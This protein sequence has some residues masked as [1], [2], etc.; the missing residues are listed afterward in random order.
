MKIQAGSMRRLWRAVMLLA[1][2][3][4]ATLLVA[5]GVSVWVVESLAGG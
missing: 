4:T 2:T 5:L 3:I 1:V